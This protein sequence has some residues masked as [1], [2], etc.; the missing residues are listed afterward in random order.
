MR[1]QWVLILFFMLIPW[2]VG[3]VVGG[4]QSGT[5]LDGAY[6]TGLVPHEVGGLEN[7]ISAYNGIPGIVSGVTY[8]YIQIDTDCSNK[9]SGICLDSDDS[10]L[11]R[12]N[13]AS[14]V[15]LGGGVLD[16]DGDGD[17]TDEDPEFATVTATQFSGLV[18]GDCSDGN[19]CTAQEILDSVTM[20]PSGGTW[21]L[22]AVAVTLPSFN[23]V[24]TVYIPI[25][26]ATDGG[27]APAAKEDINDTAGYVSVRKF[28]GASQDEDV[29][30]TWQ[31][32]ADIVAAS[33]IKFR[34][35]CYIT[36]A[37]GPSAETWQMEMQG[38]SVADGEALAGTLG[39]AQASNS[40]S[41]SDA[42]YDRVATAWSS[43][44]TTTHI[45]GL[46]AGETAH[47]K[48][49]RDIDDTDTY[50]QDVGVAGIEIKYYRA[51]TS[52]GF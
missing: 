5:S 39:T 38:F 28:D 2:T 24:E 44:L 17:L 15:L 27:T 10:N 13:G 14:M 37:T 20:T 26:Y 51:L 29:M 9:T 48:L 32:P 52:S 4:G 33:G 45:T 22:S 40:G 50:A 31:V 21:D 23:I 1:K 47:L 8:E 41:R 49:Y 6:I 46:A 36:E 12:W 25:G 34:A 16:T 7:D 43:A 19:T 18:I 30:I 11:Y 3:F 35:I 42:Q